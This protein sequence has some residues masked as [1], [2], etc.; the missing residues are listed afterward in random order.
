MSSCWVRSGVDR[1]AARQFLKGIEMKRWVA[2]LLVFSVSILCSW[3]ASSPNVL[4][5]AI[6]DLNDWVGALGGHPQALT[7]NIDR[8]ASRGVSFVN[9]HCQAPLCNSSRTSLMTGLRPSTTGVHG[10]GPWFRKV[11]PFADVVTLP[12]ALSKA[13][14]TTLMGGKIYHGGYGRQADLEWDVVGPGASGRPFPEE[15]LVDTPSQNR[16]V[17]WGEFDHKDQEKGDWIVADWAVEQ[18]NQLGKQQ[19]DPFFLATGFFLPHVPCYATSKWF[20]LYPSV[21]LPEIQRLDRDDTPRFSWYLHWQLP[22]PRL[23]FLEENDEWSNLV[24]SYLACVSFVDSQVGRVL[25]ALELNGLSEDTMVV[26]WSDHGFHLGEKLITG[27]NTLW[28]E[29]TRVPLVF[30]GPGVAAGESADCAAELLDIYPTLLDMLDLEPTQ[31]L[32]G[33]SLAP[34]LRDPS[35]TRVRPAITT[36]NQ[37]NHGVVSKRWRYIVYADGSEELY[38]RWN[39]PN[40]WENL[41]G[42]PEHSSV[43]DW[44]RAQLPKVDVPAAPGSHSRILERINGEIVWEGRVISETDP[45][46]EI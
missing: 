16:L 43:V 12:Q 25:D 1:G 29:S 2:K 11:E 17:D 22:E 37:G 6:D 24:R 5:I 26:L 45:I 27:K 38:D 3:G 42:K 10:L 36:H 34:Q 44:H 4:F 15:K 9:A 41:I 30:A 32:E 33:I 46:P 21:S 20:D 31:G 23:R 39:D 19:R 18:L 7:P 13:G 28:S 35:V 8:L 40:E 14:Y